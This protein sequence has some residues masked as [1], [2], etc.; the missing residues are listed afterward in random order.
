MNM[1]AD[2]GRRRLHRA[3]WKGVAVLLLGLV[4]PGTAQDFSQTQ[5]SNFRAPLE[6]FP[7]PNSRQVKTLLQGAN[8][9]PLENGRILLTSV[10]LE[11][12]HTNGTPQLV[13]E[14]PSCIFDS[15]MRS[16]EST[17]ALEVRTADGNFLLQGT[18][19]SLQTTNSLLLVSNKVHTIVYNAPNRLNKP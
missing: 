15:V 16:I 4:L 3:A 11:I 19:Y 12:L 9:E 14:S 2:T 10:R 8:A 5:F 13:A 6:T 1:R 17:N 18:G 7:P